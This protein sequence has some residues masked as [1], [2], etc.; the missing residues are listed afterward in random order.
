MFNPTESNLANELT[1]VELITG[2]TGLP[3]V[4]PLDIGM[5][6]SVNS[7]PAPP[8]S[9]EA[10]AD[11]FTTGADSF[12]DAGTAYR[13]YATAS[14]VF[15]TKGSRNQA[16]DLGED[17]LLGGGLS[18][19]ASLVSGRSQNIR[20]V[21]KQ[22]LSQEALENAV[23]TFTADSSGK[24]SVDFRFERGGR[25]GELAIFS[26]EEMGGLN[27]KE[28]V[29]EASRRAL[30]GGNQG[31]IVIKDKTEAAQF[32]G[33]LLGERN[34][35][36]G[37][38]AKTQTVR[39]SPRESFAVMLVPGGTVA[40]A[41]A[42]NQT[43]F[44]SIAEFNPKGQTQIAK[45]SNN[46]FAMEEFRSDRGKAD[47]NDVIFRLKGAPSNAKPL[48]Q[49]VNSRNDWRK[50]PLAKR[51]LKE[52]GFSPDPDPKPPAPGPIGPEDPPKPNTPKSNPPKTGSGGN[53]QVI[54]DI[55][56]AVAKFNGNS[57]QAQI[58]ASGANSI[59]IGS[60]TIYIGT[61]QVSSNNQNPI[62]RSFDPK[63]PKNNWKRRDIETSGTDGRGYG[64]LWTVKSLY[65]VFSVDGTQNDGT[66]FRKAASGAQLNWLKS[67]GF[68]GG[69]RIGI[70]GQIDP[71]TGKLLK[72]AHLSA[73]TSSGRTNT[74]NISDATVNGKGNL[75]IKA[76]SFFS[77]RQPDGSAKEQ[78]PGNNADSPFDYTVELTSDLSRVVKT[79]APGWS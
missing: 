37:K 28:F 56:T 21:R 6:R 79:T 20:S 18:R 44:F 78:K 36:R 25:T 49:L 40:D 47:F 16:L 19:S 58:I 32:S 61:E 64:L 11:V 23:G 35:N 53:D 5:R 2:E 22:G 9:V 73:I 34:F 76:K 75:V 15:G 24:V 62:L 38:T 65:G 33:S 1:A 46:T 12:L 42:G 51:F 7:L 63:N 31:Q 59:T 55:S 77:P 71:S 60:Q 39:F 67:Y 68:G 52:P 41:R 43:P 26:L 8:S 66:D 17:S 29:K 4:G 30:K 69:A 13:E 14:A 3:A 54:R 45:A 50:T 57:T 74:L 48:G 70:I 72:A 27:Q 10:A